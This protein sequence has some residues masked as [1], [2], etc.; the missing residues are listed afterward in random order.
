M[1]LFFL[2]VLTLDILDFTFTI[3]PEESNEQF[4]YLILVN[5]NHKLP[6]DYESKVNLINVK[7]NIPKDDRTFQLEKVTHD[8]FV[9]L[10]EKLLEEYNITIELDSAYRSVARQQEIW[11]EFVEKYGLNY[12]E[13]YVAK[14]GYSEHHTG[15]ALD[16]CLVVNGT[17][18]DDND[19]MIK[20]K[21][22]FEK[23]HKKLSD[24]G[25][26]LRYLQGKESIT[27]YNYEPWHFRFVQIDDAKKIMNEGI[28]L[29]EYL[30]KNDSCILNYNLLILF[31][32]FI[33]LIF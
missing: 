9:K 11:D 8:Y 16:I 32:I 33:C 31:I 28:T 30:S 6:D 22:I 13:K 21:E 2:L 3:A 17:V 19:E 20:Q 23:I 5:K 29:E 1:S 18:I 7:N 12:T 24:Y 15:L 27:G 26:I 4:N 10:R 14:P 25:F